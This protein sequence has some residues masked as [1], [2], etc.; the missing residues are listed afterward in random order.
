M[1]GPCRPAHRTSAIPLRN[2]AACRRA[3]DDD[4]KHDPSP[5]G[6]RFLE[7]RS[8]NVLQAKR[9]EKP[10]RFKGGHRQDTIPLS[11][12]CHARKSTCVKRRIRCPLLAGGARIHVD[13]HAD[14]HFD[15]FWCFPGHLALLFWNRTHS[16]LSDKVMPNQKF[17]SKIFFLRAPICIFAAPR[18][19]GVGR[20]ARCSKPPLINGFSSRRTGHEDR[21]KVRRRGIGSR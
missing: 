2:T 6:L 20:L 13:F 8:F 19:D 10:K 11:G 5:G 16:A 7:V 1:L 4:A 21:G 18:K 9:V 15:D 17:A 12:T 3:Q 14:R